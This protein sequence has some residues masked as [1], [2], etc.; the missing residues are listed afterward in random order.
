MSDGKRIGGGKQGDD[1]DG[2]RLGN[3]GFKTLRVG[4]RYLKRGVYCTLLMRAMPTPSPE[5]INQTLDR[6][7]TTVVRHDKTRLS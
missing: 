3:F 4:A 6:Y 1:R 5:S 2:C 7:R